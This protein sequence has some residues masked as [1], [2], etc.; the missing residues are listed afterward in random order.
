[1]PMRERTLYKEGGEKKENL[2]NPAADGEDHRWGL[3]GGFC[4]L[5]QMTLLGRIKK[6]GSLNA[7][8]RRVV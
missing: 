1:M 5:H 8:K 3:E 7:G 4:L 6:K 2:S